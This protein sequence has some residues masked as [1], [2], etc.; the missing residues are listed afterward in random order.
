MSHAG[1]YW[2]CTDRPWTSPHEK[3]PP[4]EC[5]AGLRPHTRVLDVL[6]K[7]DRP[8]SAGGAGIE[9]GVHGVERICARADQRTR[10]CLLPVVVWRLAARGDDQCGIRFHSRLDAGAL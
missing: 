8:D 1:L 2:L 9:G 5:P 3:V 6:L 10:R 7:R 4:A